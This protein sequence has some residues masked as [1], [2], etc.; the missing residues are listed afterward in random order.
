MQGRLELFFA[1][2]LLVVNGA[3][4]AEG[5]ATRSLRAAAGGMFTMGVGINDRIPE[6]PGDWAL[7][8]AQFS[9]VT[10]ENCLKPNPVQVAEGKFNF[11][12]ADGFVDFARSNRLD[13]VGHCLVWA[14]DD[15]TPPWFFRDGTNAAGRGLLLARMKTCL[16]Y[17]SPSPRDS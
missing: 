15:R 6:R 14:K 8:K 2:T 1:L 16:L 4:G 12:L 9:V 11:A 7:L 17:T 10:P 13:V 3:G 5:G